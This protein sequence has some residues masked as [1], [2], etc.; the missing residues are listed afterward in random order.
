MV[1]T[2][3]LDSIDEYFVIDKSINLEELIDKV[4]KEG[5]VYVLSDY[6]ENYVIDKLISIEGL[7][8]EN[9]NIS[10]FLVRKLKPLNKLKTIFELSN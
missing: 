10:W 7:K 8:V 1:L 5:F 2:Y 4:E 9:F 3:N 6:K